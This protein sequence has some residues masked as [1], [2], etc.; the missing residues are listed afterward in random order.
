VKRRAWGLV[1]WAWGLGTLFVLLFT[2]VHSGHAQDRGASTL[3]AALRGVGVN[4]RVLIIGAHPD[5]ED[6]QV[7]AWLSRGRHVET[8]YLSLTRGDGGQNAIG[9]ELGEALG[10]IRTEELLAARRV[11]GGKQFFTRAYD[12]G[13][14]KNAEEAF[15]QWPHDSLLRDVLTVVR[16][17]KP[18]VIISVFT[19]TPRDGHG[20]HQAA[21]ILA[22]EAYDWSGD[23]AR[24][25]RDETWGHGGWTVS[26]FYRGASFR[27]ENATLSFNVGEYDPVLGRSYAEIAAISRS[28]HRS[29]AF[30]TLQP[31]GVRMDFLQREASRVPA[32]PDP[33]A[34]R[35]LFDGIDTTWA[36][37]R[38]EVAGAG[39]RA[40]LDSLPAAL[41][42]ARSSFDP[43]EPHRSIPAL[44][45]V[46]DLLNRVCPTA[47][48]GPPCPRV[49]GNFSEITDAGLSVA[50]ARAR[51]SDALA[52]AAGV[53]VEA[54]MPRELW[55]VGEV[56]PVR[57]TL[58]NR[59]K[60]PVTV[61][62]TS[63]LI[64]RSL[65]TANRAPI[66][67][68]PDSSV[69]IDIVDGN[70]SG[71]R[72]VDVSAPYWLSPPRQGAMFGFPT[73][74]SDE[75]AYAKSA[76]VGLHLAVDGV[77]FS[78][79]API[80][81]RFADQVK[82]EIRRTIAGVPAVSVLLD[83]A[84][85]YAP[86]RA[87]IQRSLRVRLQTPDSAPR[88]VHL[89][90]RLPAGLTA[91]SAIRTVIVPGSNVVHTVEFQVRGTLPV[92]RH[93]IDVAAI[94]SSGTYAQ[95][96]TTIDYEHM[97]PRRLYRASRLTIEAVDLT[98]GSPM[99][100]AYIAGVGDNSAPALEQL[101][102]EVTMLEPEQLAT[103]NLRGYS[104]V[105]V[106]P[107]AYEASPVLVANNARLLDYARDGGT[108]V[109]QYGQYEMQ[110][111]GMMPYPITINR[112][113][114]RVTDET[115]PVVIIDSTNAVLRSPNR[116]TARDFDGWLQDRSLYMP[117]TFDPAYI[118][119]LAMNDPGEVPN[120]GALLV[121][122]YG[123]GTYVY[124]TLAFFR[125]LPNGVPGAARLFVNLLAA[126]AGRTAQ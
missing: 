26:K 13:F 40:A 53:V 60:R 89:E 63:V 30:G 100:V 79:H 85:Q 90:A 118:P 34:E 74:G 25:S 101:G 113:H 42:A 59:G 112:P 5:D 80:V 22:R 2:T 58:Y 66:T 119:V 72:F 20:Q 19:G 95:G 43:F 71:H 76:H 68:A 16:S 50:I 41:L 29:Q 46:S 57:P 36:R 83:H 102:I 104:A 55:S 33:K 64:E 94:D 107:R 82:G 75:A 54:A 116:L 45:R 88:A 10:V 93:T 86:A 110:R 103:A 98:V 21:G 8:A 97:N 120:R 9:N 91:D 92:G 35:S 99:R 81:R 124:T 32:P 47:Q 108:L 70:G 14:S 51:V 61:T 23:T 62:G 1:P 48:G 78:A 67:V 7:I 28:Q 24:V 3:G 44:A 87:P 106:G 12:Y 39:A 121:A 109:V 122:P 123:R 125:Q 73:L 77:E 126:K 37:V 31:L 18:H 96:Y 49:R 6:T 56:L 111:P 52:L 69:T 4:T 84:V 38:P 65:S 17:F 15:T 105:V 117:R 114:D 11:D 115:A 27:R